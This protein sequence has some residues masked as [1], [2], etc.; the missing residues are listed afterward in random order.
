MNSKG[1]TLIEMLIAVAI[2]AILAAIAM[3]SYQDSIMK[4][5]RSDGIAALLKLQLAQEKFR[6]NC[7]FYA[8]TFAAA[9]NCGV[10]AANSSLNFSTTSE[11]G[12]YTISVTAAA[13]NGYTITA[14]PIGSQAAD[15]DCD[16]LQYI[17]P[18]GIKSPADCWD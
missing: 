9:D 2:V 14:D 5:R 1:F 16:P 7:R 6:S 3:P 8:G 11:E 13:G 17:Y 18:A 10:D 15:G 4:S 12:F